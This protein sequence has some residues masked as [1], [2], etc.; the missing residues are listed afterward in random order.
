V[1][2]GGSDDVEGG[3]DFDA[4]DKLLGE[5]AAGKPDLTKSD[6]PRTDEPKPDQDGTDGKGEPT[7]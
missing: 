2:R 4:L 3:I 6:Q 5:A 1:H 7:A